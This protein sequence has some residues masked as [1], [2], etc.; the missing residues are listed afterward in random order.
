MSFCFCLCVDLELLQIYK[1]QKQLTF[2]YVVLSA[3]CDN[4][5]CGLFKSML[6]IPISPLASPLPSTTATMTDGAC[7]DT[8]EDVAGDRWHEEHIWMLLVAYSSFME[9]ICKVLSLVV[10]ISSV[11]SLI[12]SSIHA[13]NLSGSHPR[14]PPCLTPGTLPLPSPSTITSSPLFPEPH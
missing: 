7:A 8:A 11:Y 1:L 4:I 10:L 3:N 9:A 13:H 6:A 12:M 5:I 2:T 14:A